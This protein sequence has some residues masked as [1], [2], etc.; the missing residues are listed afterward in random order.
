MAI[1]PTV[2]CTGIDGRRIRYGCSPAP[3]RV[4]LP[5]RYTPGHGP[6]PEGG[7]GEERRRR[8]RG[9]GCQQKCMGSLP[10]KAWVGRGRYVGSRERSR[11]GRG[12]K[13]PLPVGPTP[14]GDIPTVQYP[15][16]S[17]RRT[18]HGSPPAHPGYGCS[19]DIAT[20]GPLPEGGGGGGAPKARVGWGRPAEAY[21]YLS[22]KVRVGW[23]LPK[24]CAGIPTEARARRYSPGST[25]PGVALV[26][27]RQENDPR[28][29]VPSDPLTPRVSL[30]SAPSP[31]PRA[32]SGASRPPPSSPGRWRPRAGPRQAP[33]RPPVYGGRSR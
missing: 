16:I 14:R 2:R 1:S 25:I 23:G 29:P 9:G 30:P 10:P 13:F 4:R 15:G 24:E 18:C 33:R 20:H 21:G 28:G 6:L 19:P 11:Q 7:A 8:G 12:N 31:R 17:R 5:T 3:P 22:A 26:Y 27:G 32:L